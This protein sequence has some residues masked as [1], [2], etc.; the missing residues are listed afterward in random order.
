MIA[1]LKV[2]VAAYAS[3][4]RDITDVACRVVCAITTRAASRRDIDGNRVATHDGFA[5][6][7]IV[8]IDARLQ[9]KRRRDLVGDVRRFAFAGCQEAYAQRDTLRRKEDFYTGAPSQEQRWHR[10]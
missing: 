8:D 7:N 10:S 9:G 5:F 3:S 4:R 2:R 1:T 6:E